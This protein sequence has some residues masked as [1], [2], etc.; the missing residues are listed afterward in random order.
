MCR[1]FYSLFHE[2]GFGFS[3]LTSKTISSPFKRRTPDPSPQTHPCPKNQ[4]RLNSA[5]DQICKMKTRGI[6]LCVFALVAC[7]AMPAVSFQAPSPIQKTPIAIGSLT[8]DLD[9]QKGDGMIDGI[10]HYTLGTMECMAEKFSKLPILQDQ[11]SKDLI[12]SLRARVENA[13]DHIRE[14]RRQR[15]AGSTFTE[16]S[17]GIKKL[18]QLVAEANEPFFA[19]ADRLPNL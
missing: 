6:V 14:L 12:K 11:D 2:S 1:I 19:L 10:E 3:P 8:R 13:K 15:A 18:L 7:S 4:C 9:I 5:Q 16:N 17:P